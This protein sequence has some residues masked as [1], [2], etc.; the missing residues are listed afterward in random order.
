MNGFQCW[1]LSKR[2]LIAC[3]FCMSIACLR[4]MGSPPETSTPLDRA[5]NTWTGTTT[6]NVP[7]ARWGHSAIWTGTEMIIWA[8]TNGS[9]VHGLTTGGRYNP[10]TDTWN[11]TSTT[12]AP[13]ARG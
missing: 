6:A 9:N 11:A 1:L 10:A 5:D 4:G 7:D 12:N 2:A 3:L 13:T 8:G